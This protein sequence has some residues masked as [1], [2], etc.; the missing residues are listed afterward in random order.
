MA[1]LKP[2][3]F[4]GGEAACGIS[5]IDSICF[6]HVECLK[7]G[8]IGSLATKREWAIIAWNNRVKCGEF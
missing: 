8:V 5:K 3:P 4:C 2:C 6:D 1:E 7:C